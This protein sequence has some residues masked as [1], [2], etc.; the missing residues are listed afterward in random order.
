MT[1]VS[2]VLANKGTHKTFVVPIVLYSS[3]CCCLRKKDEQRILVVEMTW[4]RR[5]L[6]VTRRDWM[7]NETVRSLSLIHI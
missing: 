6:R 4:L 3:E 1:K 7:K 2:T 5:L